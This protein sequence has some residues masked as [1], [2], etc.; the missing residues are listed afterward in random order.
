MILK[1][2]KF[3][4]EL[5]C[6]DVIDSPG[7]PGVG[8]G[9]TVREAIGEWVYYNAKLL[10]IDKFELPDCEYERISDEYKKG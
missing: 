6:A 5:F 4:D 9:K 2:Y 7:S 1:V 3:S 8:Y 10:N